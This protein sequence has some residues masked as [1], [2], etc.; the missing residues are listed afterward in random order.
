[1]E[2]TLNVSLGKRS[3]PLYI[4]NKNLSTIGEKLRR[5]ELRERATIISNPQI[6]DLYGDT[7]KESL[8]EEKIDSNV[9]LVEA[10]E[11]S[12][13]L[14]EASKIYDKLISSKNNRYMPIIALGGGVIGDLAGFI[15]ATYMRGVP[16]VQVPTTLLAQVDSSVGGKVAVNHPEAKN[17]IG[18]FYQPKFV[19][20]DMDTLKTLPERE[21]ISGLAEIL[22]YA[23]ISADDFMSFLKANIDPILNKNADILTDVVIRCCRK[24]AKIVEEDEHDYGLRAVLNFGHTIGHSI[25]AISKYEN[26]RHGEAVALGLIGA[27][28]VSNIKGYAKDE[29]V[30]ETRN[31]LK[32]LK[33]PSQIENLSL[34]E[35]IEHVKLDKK[36]MEGKI[37]FVMVKSPGEVI[38]ENV[39]PEIIM[40][41]LKRA[42]KEGANA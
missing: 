41:A 12:K 36:V 25:E 20:A 37:R 29:L 3:Y 17:I 18:S 16:Y 35:I 5:H 2:K 8:K 38:V 27:V 21:Y 13:S 14:Q 24:K 1:M 34:D 7:V 15:A 30:D 23:F 32:D 6:M 33:L 10:G 28:I 31:L 9:I 4:G 40:E 11:E 19:L 39:E 42:T 26:F 22:K